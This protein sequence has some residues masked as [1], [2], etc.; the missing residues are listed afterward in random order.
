M[1]GIK[2]NGRTALLQFLDGGVW[3]GIG[4]CPN[5]QQYITVGLND[6]KKR[7]PNSRVRAIDK[8]T[9]SLLDMMI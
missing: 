6:L 8:D 1:G 9:G 7:Y 4:G 2:D 5:N 3:R